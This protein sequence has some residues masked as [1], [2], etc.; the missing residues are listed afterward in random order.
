M[1]LKTTRMNLDP[2]RLRGRYDRLKNDVNY[3]DVTITSHESIVTA[4]KCVLATSSE[5]FK[6]LFHQAEMNKHHMNRSSFDLNGFSED[7]SKH[8]ESVIDFLYS[9]TVYMNDINFAGIVKMAEYLMI[10]ELLELCERFLHQNATKQN[11]LRLYLDL[12]KVLLTDTSKDA[13]MISARTNSLLKQV[14]EM[15]ETHFYDYII[16]HHEFLETLPN[17][18]ENMILENFKIGKIIKLAQRWM[19]NWPLGFTFADSLINITYDKLADVNEDDLKE[20]NED[21]SVVKAVLN[22]I[23]QIKSRTVPKSN[24]ANMLMKL[25]KILKC[26]GVEVDEPETEINDA[27]DDVDE[28]DKIDENAEGGIEDKSENI[29]DADNETNEEEKDKEAM[30]TDQSLEKPQEEDYVVTANVDTDGNDD[31]IDNNANAN[32]DDDVEINDDD[33]GDN[34]DNDSGVRNKDAILRNVDLMPVKSNTEKTPSSPNND[35]FV[36]S[37]YVETEGV[38][39]LSAKDSGKYLSMPNIEESG[40]DANNEKTAEKDDNIEVG[41]EEVLTEVNTVDNGTTLEQETEEEKETTDESKAEAEHEMDVDIKKTS[42]TDNQPEDLTSQTEGQKPEDKS[43][44]E[45]EDSTQENHDDAEKSGSMVTESE[46]LETDTNVKADEEKVE[47]EGDEEKQEEKSEE[48]EV[49][50]VDDMENLDAEGDDDQDEGQ[51][52]DGTV[53]DGTADNDTA[54]N[55]TADDDNAE[56][57]D[58]DKN[59]MSMDV[60][61]IDSNES[62]KDD[63]DYVDDADDDDDGDDDDFT[64]IKD[65]IVTDGVSV[66]SEEAEPILDEEETLTKMIKDRV[67]ECLSFQAKQKS[68]F[69]GIR[70]GGSKS[71]SKRKRNWF[72]DDS[73]PDY[74]VPAPKSGRKK[75]STSGSSRRSKRKSEIPLIEDDD[76]DTGLDVDNTVVKVEVDAK[77]HEGEDVGGANYQSIVGDKTIE[78]QD[79]LNEDI[80]NAFMQVQEDNGIFNDSF[81]STPSKKRR[82]STPRKMH[83]CEICHKLYSQR[84]RLRQHMN[85]HLGI[86]PHKCVVCSQMFSRTDHVIRHMKTQHHEMETFECDVCH[87]TFEKPNEVVSHYINH[88]S[89]DFE[90]EKQVKTVFTE[91][92]KE[93]INITP[94]ESG[95]SQYDCKLCEKTFKKPYQ[96]REHVNSHTGNKPHKC[97]Q[98]GSAYAKKDNLTTH[99]RMVHNGMKG[100]HT[101]VKCRKTFMKK[102]NYDAHIETCAPNHK[103]DI[104]PMSFYRKTH[105]DNHL[106]SHTTTPQVQCPHCDSKFKYRKH[107]N[108]HIKKDHTEFTPDEGPSECIC[109]QCGVIVKNKEA[110]YRHRKVHKIPDKECD[111]CGKA[112]KDNTTLKDHK[113]MH[114]NIRDYQCEICSMLFSRKGNLVRHQK[115]HR[116]ERKYRCDICGMCFVANCDLTRHKNTHLG[117]KKFPCRFCGRK[118]GLK[119]KV[120]VHERTHT[121]ERPYFCREEN[122]GKTFKQTGDRVR[123]EKKVHNLVFNKYMTL[124]ELATGETEDIYK[125]AEYEKME[126][127]MDGV[128]PDLLSAAAAHV[129]GVGGNPPMENNTNLNTSTLDLSAIYGPPMMN[130]GGSVSTGGIMPLNNTD[131]ISSVPAHGLNNMGVPTSNPVLKNDPPDVGSAIDAAVQL[132]TTT[133]LRSV[134]GMTP[135][136]LRLQPQPEAPMDENNIEDIEMSRMFQ[137]TVAQFSSH[138]M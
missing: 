35:N 104:C 86:K 107:L 60:D 45:I 15:V 2:V 99:I 82:D 116:G 53:D 18:V 129:P 30:E 123:H 102:E 88:L 59:E 69:V 24:K 80:F 20:D 62:F 33:N 64:D 65:R 68:E 119:S 58:N 3:K 31:G 94:L 136:D 85:M 118:F 90:I 96:A 135:T 131:P 9:G 25:V 75:K 26:F 39:D 13:T 41:S 101:C 125:R 121:G 112:F 98:C 70:L 132:A 120:T 47:L 103:C 126:N 29:E 63:N 55:D 10:D 12:K 138:M 72:I 61:N 22:V 108:R 32:D 113:L 19:K 109:D 52:L 27:N 87:E 93:I 117:V 134:L 46:V 37:N 5:F 51:K 1:K 130:P 34:D 122:C 43:Q 7:E 124:Y 95:K 115:R 17:E 137:R 49:K 97:D 4:H 83:E 44:G 73:D 40:N 8:L 114:T 128:K 79:S 81:E 67:S 111:V 110:L 57:V 100:E 66:K 92:E 36:G 28:S 56:D 77:S 11:Y 14:W 74:E 16:D 127:K 23:D 91:E 76:V 84:Y 106:I 89:P 78:K 50:G 133:A 6:E 48:E 42:E 71:K 105:L 54:A 21:N 38:L